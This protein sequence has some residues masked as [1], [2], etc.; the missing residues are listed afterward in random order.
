MKEKK[1]I[2]IGFKVLIIF[3]IGVTLFFSRQKNRELFVEFINNMIQEENIG[4]EREK[5][6]KTTIPLGPEIDGIGFYG[7]D[8]VVLENQKLSRYK[9]DGSI[10][11]EKRFDLDKP[12]LRF[13][14]DRIYISDKTTGEIYIL[15]PIGE[16][17]GKVELNSNIKNVIVDFNNILVH[18]IDDETNIE[19]M[20]ILSRDGDM[21]IDFPI[22]DGNLLTYSLSRD[23]KSYIVSTL[24]L[25]KDK[26]KSKMQIFKID[27]K[28]LYNHTFND[29]ILLYSNFIEKNQLVAMSDN[30]LYLLENQN[31][32]WEKKIPLIKDI[33]IHENKIHVLYGN[34]L[35]ILSSEGETKFKYSFTEEY[36]EISLSDNH[37][38]VYGDEYIIGLEG[39]NEIFKY[40]LDG[41]IQNV[42]N[43]KE[44]LIINYKDRID[45]LSL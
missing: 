4:E 29:E 30:N 32:L 25:S 17:L 21:V 34:T 22:K 39:G 35:E 23:K 33:A 12:M 14:E 36:N 13:G 45:I 27:G 44:N 11:W 3:V 26:L 40:K 6:I 15:N 5:E 10:L 41:E 7:D 8:I 42:I 38:F 43:N 31:I 1:K 9:T 19:R 2:G 28:E 18:T 24:D 37:I 20:K 16:I